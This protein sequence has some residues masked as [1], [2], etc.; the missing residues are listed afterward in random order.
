MARILLIAMYNEFNL[1]VRQMIS[2]LRDAGH[3][4]WLLCLKRLARKDIS[5]DEEWY[6]YWQI[7]LPPNGQRHVV[8]YPHPLS[9]CE[10]ELFKGLLRKLR[11]QFVGLSIYSAFVPSAVEVTRLIRET[12]PEA[13]VGWGGPHVTLDPVSSSEHCDMAFVGECDLPMVELA[14]A[15]H[16]GKDWR[17]VPNIVWRENGSI[18][19]QPVSPV[20]KDLDTLPFTYYGSDGVLYLED[21]ELVEGRPFRGSDLH[22]HFKIMT[23]RGCPYVCT[24]CMLSFQK[25]V[26]PDTTRLRFRSIPHVMR[27][28]EEAKA[29]MGHFFLEIEDDI[30]TTRPE[31][32]KEFFQHYRER[33]GMP[34]WCY[35]H[36]NYARP[37]MLEVLKQNNVQFVVMG[38]QSGSDRIANEIFDRRVSNKTLLE[39]TRNIHKAGIRPFYDLISNNP[40]ESEED[41]IETFHLLRSIPR[42]YGLQ[43]V[44]LTFY[45]NLGISRMR[46]E[47]GLPLTVDF[48]QYRFWNSLYHLASTVELSDGDAEYLLNNA[49]FRRDPSLLERFATHAKAWTR[50]IGDLKA[51]N[52][53]HLQEVH[54]LADRVRALEEELTFIKAR[55]GFRQ[56]L[57]LSEQLRH[58][59]HKLVNWRSLIHAREEGPHKNA[60]ARTDSLR[61]KAISPLCNQAKKL[62]SS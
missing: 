4:A 59:K 21:D 12:L 49:E 16:H 62:S 53:T 20:I 36:P 41:R 50:E 32:M 10:R 56:F 15:L 42:P 54:R 38:I 22:T 7:E 11:P 25:E 3:E 43:L 8:C 30:F 27:E 29:R 45:P 24:F 6:P 39:A 34:F 1:G 19:R 60:G 18:H 33:I 23:T 46:E 40:F 13:L 28:L 2:E 47:R 9:D 31:R 52:Q 26:M 37:E 5:P 48:Q 14:H 35:T 58:L 44:A 61:E 51:L 57:W 55:R 17:Q